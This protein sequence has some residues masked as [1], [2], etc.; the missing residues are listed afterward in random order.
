MN[1]KLI[2]SSAIAGLVALG[3]SGGAMAQD[4]KVEKEK[5]YGIAKKAANDCGTASH[6]CAGK[7]AADNVPDE[8]KFVAKG[9]CEKMGGK[10]KVAAKADKP[11]TP[12][13]AK[14]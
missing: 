10:V 8:W 5:C 2:V 4:K 11:A 7:A 12:E 13:P 9:S 3:A 14:Y 1:S 6:S